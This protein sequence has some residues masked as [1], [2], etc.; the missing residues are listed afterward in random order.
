MNPT[1]KSEIPIEITQVYANS[2]W[3]N[4]IEGI[5]VSVRPEFLTATSR[6]W[7]RYD[8]D[9]IKVIRNPPG[10][11]RFPFRKVHVSSFQFKI[12]RYEDE[13]L[14]I[15]KQKEKQ[16]LDKPSAP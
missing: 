1:N 10:A 6:N 16:A 13:L 12:P 11:P 14:F 2:R 15:R 9:Q 7:W 4:Q 5:I 8:Q 3:K